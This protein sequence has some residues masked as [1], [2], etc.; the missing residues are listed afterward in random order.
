MGTG[1]KCL[2]G[3][4]NEKGDDW[5]SVVF[6][7]EV[8]ISTAIYSH[9]HSAFADE[10]TVLASGQAGLKRMIETIFSHR[11]KALF[12]NT[13]QHEI[14]NHEMTNYLFLLQRSH[15]YTLLFYFMFAS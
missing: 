11:K 12:R 15:V 13:K 7:A 10:V 8:S 1:K 9:L 6:R 14:S 5:L 2:K 4:T 3:L